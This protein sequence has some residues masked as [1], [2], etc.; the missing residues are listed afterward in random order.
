MRKYY[1]LL[2]YRW[3]FYR[4]GI[5]DKAHA[6]DGAVQRDKREISGLYSDV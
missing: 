2:F 5:H 6:D 3:N 1:S 4:I